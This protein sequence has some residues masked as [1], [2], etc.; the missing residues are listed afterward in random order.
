MS[1]HV[2]LFIYFILLQQK[3]ILFALDYVQPNATRNALIL[4]FTKEYV[5]S[6]MK[7]AVVLMISQTL[8]NLTNSILPPWRARECSGFAWH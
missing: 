4:D 8:L 6:Q 2:N 3:K 7:I 1:M 5:S